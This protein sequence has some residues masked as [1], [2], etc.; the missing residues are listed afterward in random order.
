MLCIYFCCFNMQLPY[1]EVEDNNPADHYRYLVVVYTGS[2]HLAGTTATVAMTLIGGR[3]KSAIHLLQTKNNR[4]LSR[5]SVIN[6][7]IT[8]PRQLGDIEAVRVWHDNSGRSPEWQVE[9]HAFYS[10]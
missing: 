2:R 10:L 6:F 1:H 3:G 9:I 4:L 5:G 7:L 8:T